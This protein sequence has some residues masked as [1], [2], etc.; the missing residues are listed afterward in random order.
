MVLFYVTSAVLCSQVELKESSSVFWDHVR[1]RGLGGIKS[2]LCFGPEKKTEAFA[3]SAAMVPL[4]NQ[5]ASALAL[6]FSKE[7]GLQPRAVVNSAFI[8]SCEEIYSRSL[9]LNSSIHVK[10]KKN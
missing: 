5:Q 3:P 10:E 1:K 4:L 8:I 6:H 2:H 9:K 7:T